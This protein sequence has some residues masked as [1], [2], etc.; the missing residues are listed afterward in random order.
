M[1]AEGERDG[2]Q[3]RFDA[4]IALLFLIVPVCLVASSILQG[5]SGQIGPDSDDVMRLVQIKDLLNGQD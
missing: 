5:S 1:P 3:V 4:K 2:V